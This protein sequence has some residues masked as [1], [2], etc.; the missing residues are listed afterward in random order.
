[1]LRHSM[2]HDTIKNGFPLYFECY[3]LV[4]QESA[5]ITDACIVGCAVV[6]E[7]RRVILGFALLCQCVPCMSC[8]VEQARELE[9]RLRC[10]HETRGK[11]HTSWF[12]SAQTPP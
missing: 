6:M 4:A 1:M 12:L 7:H 2:L 10:A 8:H 9:E 5:P 11:E 3:L